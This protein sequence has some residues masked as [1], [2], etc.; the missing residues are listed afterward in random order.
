MKV[1]IFYRYALINLVT[2]AML[3]D[4]GGSQPPIGAPGGMPS[5]A[6]R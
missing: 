3:A 5:E 6:T 2:T 1:L 4:R